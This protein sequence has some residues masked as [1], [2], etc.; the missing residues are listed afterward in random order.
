M[1]KYGPGTKA[2]PDETKIKLRGSVDL[3]NNGTKVLRDDHW[4]C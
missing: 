1:G 4:R 3:A 2:K